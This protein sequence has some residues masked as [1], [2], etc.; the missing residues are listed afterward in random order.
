MLFSE[1]T[2]H[3]TVYLKFLS[4]NRSVYVA[5]KPKRFM[6]EVK[7]WNRPLVVMVCHDIM[8]V[9]PDT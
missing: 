8:T 9:K 4:I 6:K 1:F 2:F 5:L 3:Y 7:T